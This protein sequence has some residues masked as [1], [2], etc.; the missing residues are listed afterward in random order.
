MIG[1]AKHEVKYTTVGRRCVMNYFYCHI[2]PGHVERDL[3]ALANFLVSLT[4]FS[5]PLNN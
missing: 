2:R 4:K 1:E 3:L 5:L